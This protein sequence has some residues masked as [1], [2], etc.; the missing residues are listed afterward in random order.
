MYLFVSVEVRFLI[1]TLG[2]VLE[3]TGV[4]LFPS[5]DDFMTDKAG[6]K[7]ELFVTIIK[8]AFVNFV[9]AIFVETVIL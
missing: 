2:A 9:L 1:E 4:R 3:I 5:V 6:L 8:G 7:V